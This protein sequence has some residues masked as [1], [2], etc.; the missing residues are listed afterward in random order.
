MS[1]DTSTRYTV[2]NVEL[3]PGD[4]LKIEGRPNGG[5]P[6]PIDYLEITP[7]SSSSR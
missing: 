6:A 1:G 5:E 2:C 7:D 4:L 3:H